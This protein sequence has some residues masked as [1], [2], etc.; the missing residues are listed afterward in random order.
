MRFDNLE[1]AIHLNSD[2]PPSL[3]LAFYIIQSLVRDI[4]A[5]SGN[6]FKNVDIGDPDEFPNLLANQCRTIRTVYENNAEQLS[7][8]QKRLSELNDKLSGIQSELEKLS[9]LTSEL[10]TVK[11]ALGEKQQEYDDLEA[12]YSSLMQQQ[13]DYLALCEE[14]ENLIADIEKLKNYDLVSKNKEKVR[15]EEEYNASDSKKRELNDQLNQL[16]SEKKAIMEE[17]SGLEELCRHQK[18]E[19]EQAQEELAAL[20]LSVADSESVIAGL[21]NDIEEYNH[22]FVLNPFEHLNQKEHNFF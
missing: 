16:E 12:E 19:I 3:T 2:E 9:K 13:K 17:N 4:E 1:V 7:G 11:K 15:L 5:A 18:D 14:C 8:N 6:K 10:R 21:Q 22:I 20:K